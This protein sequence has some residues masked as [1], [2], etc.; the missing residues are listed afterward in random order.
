MSTSSATAAGSP[1]DSGM[2]TTEA[3]Q[4]HQANSTPAQRYERRNRKQ[5]ER[6]GHETSV[7]SGDRDAIGDEEDDTFVP[8]GPIVAQQKRRMVK[9]SFTSASSTR[10]LRAL[11]AG[12]S[13]K[14][15]DSSAA[16]KSTSKR[17]AASSKDP[18]LDESESDTQSAT[19]PPKRQRRQT[20]KERAEQRAAAAKVQ[21]FFPEPRGQ[22]TVWADVSQFPSDVA[23]SELTLFQDRQSLC[24][25]LHYFQGFKSA[26]YPYKGRVLGW[27]LDNDNDE[28][29]YMDAEIVISRL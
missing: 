1:V 23:I 10:R 7:S 21:E 3:D 8:A 29:G 5:T 15:A 17:K 16:T 6:Y 20:A 22:P 25:A 26:I 14:L 4:V 18:D 28:R 27:L 2:E 9:I 11:L 12:P 19:N 13:R 24:E